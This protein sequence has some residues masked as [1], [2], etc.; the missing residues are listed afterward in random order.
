MNRNGIGLG[1]VI[2]EKIVSMFDGY[3]DFHSVPDEGS[4]FIFTF[5]LSNSTAMNSLVD[6]NEDS[7]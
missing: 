4:T 7:Y 1:L 6:L 5:K 2:S 3:I